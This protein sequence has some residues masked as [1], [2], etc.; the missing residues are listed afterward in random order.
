MR[1]RR[2]HL[3][4]NAIHWSYPRGSYGVEFRFG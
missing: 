3:G 2:K 1:N 4:K